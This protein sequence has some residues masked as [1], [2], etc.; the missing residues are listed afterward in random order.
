MRDTDLTNPEDIE[1]EIAQLE[2]LRKPLE[3][4]TFNHRSLTNRINW[5]ATKADQLRAQP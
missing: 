3:P 4:W 2:A 5:L 1:L